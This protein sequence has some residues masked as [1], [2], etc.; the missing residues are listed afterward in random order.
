MGIL[1]AMFGKVW[2]SSFSPWSRARSSKNSTKHTSPKAQILTRTNNPSSL[3]KW[4]QQSRFLALGR[5][6][7]M[8]AKR[9]GCGMLAN[10]GR[11]MPL[12][13]TMGKLQLVAD[14]R[15][16]SLRAARHWSSY[17]S[18]KEPSA[19]PLCVCQPVAHSLT[20]CQRCKDPRAP[21]VKTGGLFPLALARP[22][23]Y[24]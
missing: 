9:G 21:P 17:R 11:K 5:F 24:K 12:L 16:T 1:Q 14:S 2:T 10:C 18:C 8:L 3:E 4:V 20:P 23:G 22:N 7:G 6:L 15:P 13:G 19:P